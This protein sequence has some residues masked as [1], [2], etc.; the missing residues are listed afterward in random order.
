MVSK[1]KKLLSVTLVLIMVLSMCPTEALEAVIDCTA[2]IA[3]A[4]G[5]II[6][7][8]TVITLSNDFEEHLLGSSFAISAKYSSDTYSHNEDT[9]SYSV[10]GPEEGLVVD[11][12][13]SCIG[14][15]DNG[16]ISIPFKATKT[17]TY[18]VTI[19]SIYGA[20]DS[21]EIYITE[22][23][24]SGY[25][26][27]RLIERKE[28]LQNTEML[29]HYLFDP[30]VDSQDFISSAIIHEKFID[31]PEYFY[32]IVL[33]DILLQQS[34]D[35]NY[36]SYLTDSVQDIGQKCIT[37]TL[38]SI[39]GYTEESLKAAKLSTLSAN[40]REQLRIAYEKTTGISNIWSAVDALVSGAETVEEYFNNLAKYAALQNVNK[41]YIAVLN[42]LNEV[43][44]VELYEHGN[45]DINASSISTACLNLIQIY[46]NKN[47]GVAKCFEESAES[48]IWDL[49]KEA[50]EEVLVLVFGSTV[51][52][53]IKITKEVGLIIA[54]TVFGADEK[55]KATCLIKTTNYIEHYLK[56]AL[57]DI[58]SDYNSNSQSASTYIAAHKLLLTCF[59]YGV[60]THKY[61]EGL[62]YDKTPASIVGTILNSDKK[63]EHQDTL[64]AL[65]VDNNKLTNEYAYITSVIGEF[66]SYYYGNTTQWVITLNTNDEF[67][68]ES[69]ILVYDGEAI[70]LSSRI[71]KR[72]GYKFLGWYYDKEG[73]I[74]FEENTVAT[75]YFTLYA[76]WEQ[77][78]IYITDYDNATNT[79][80][81]GISYMSS[82]VTF[83]LD[84]S[85]K[86]ANTVIE[87][88]AYID[89]YEITRISDYGFAGCDTATSIYVPNTITHIGEYAFSNCTSLLELFIPENVDSIG[90]SIL[91]NCNSDE[92]KIVG[93][94]GSYVEVYANLNNYVFIDINGLL[95]TYTVNSSSG[96]AT[97]TGLAVDYTPT[98]L[99]I[100]NVIDGYKVIAIGN[101]AFKDCTNLVSVVIKD[102]ITSIYS[103]AFKNCNNIVTIELSDSITTISYGAFWNCS[104][105]NSIALGENVSYIDS[106]AFNYCNSLNRVYITDFK[107]WCNINFAGVSSNPLYYAQNL[108]LNNSKLQGEF[109]IPDGVTKIPNYTFKN[110]DIT[111]VTF[112]ASVE[113]IGEQAFYNCKRLQEI[114][115]TN[116][117]TSIGVCAF[118]HCSN[119]SSISLPESLTSIRFETFDECI[120]LKEVS[121]PRSITAIGEYAFSGCSNLKTVKIKD[122]EAWCKID[123][124]WWDYRSSSPLANSADLYLNDE[125]VTEL[126]I[127]SNI[128]KLNKFT[129]AGCSSITSVSIPDSVT[130]IE[131]GVFENCDNL[132]SVSISD[133]VTS[134]GSD[135]FYSC[136]ALEII[137][138][139]SKI[140]RIE[141]RTF[142]GCASLAE[143]SIPNNITSIGLYAFRDCVKLTKIEIPDSVT[144]LSSGAFQNT[145]SLKYIK[146][147]N[148][149]TSSIYGIFTG[150]Y[151]LEEIVIGEGIT[152]LDR[153]DINYP[154][155]FEDWTSLKKVVLGSN[156]E[157]IG[158]YSFE[159][160]SSLEEINI[161]EKVTE[162]PRYTFHNCSSLQQIELPETV[163]KIGEGAFRGCTNLEVINMPEKLQVIDYYAFKDC[164]NLREAILSDE[165][166]TIGYEA[167][168]NCINLKKVTVGGKVTDIYY[169]TFFGCKSLEEIELSEGLLRIGF[170][171]WGNSDSLDEGAFQGCESLEYILLPDSLTAIACNT[172]MDCSNI[173]NIIIPT[174]VSEIETSTFEN[175]TALSKITLHDGITQIHPSAFH[176]TYI[177]NNQESWENGVLYIDSCLIESNDTV[178]SDYIIKDGTV[179]IATGAFK[180]IDLQSIVIPS[181]VQN[182]GSYAFYS[183][184]SWKL[185]DLFYGGSKD[186]WEELIAKSPYTGIGNMVNIHYEAPTNHYTIIESVEATCTTEGKIISNCLC[187]YSKTE[188]IEALGHNNQVIEFMDV[189]CTQ[190]GYTKYKCLTCEEENYSYIWSEGHVKGE[191]LQVVQPTCVENGHTE[192]YCVVCNEICIEYLMPL[193]HAF[194]SGVCLNCNKPQ[195]DCIESSHNYENNC[196]K[197]WVINKLNVDYITIT[198]SSSTETE[199]GWDYIYIY[200]ADDNEIG[201]YTGTELASKEITVNGSVVKIRLTSD[202]SVN[203]YGFALSNV[204]AYR[205]FVSNTVEVVAENTNLDSLAELKVEEADSG[206]IIIS[207]PDNVSQL[208]FYDIYFEKDDERIQPE[209]VVTV[210]IPVP[211]NINGINCKV[212][213]IDDFGNAT[214]MNA[215]YTDG[216]M[217]FT[218]DHFSYYALAE[219][220]A[221]FVYGDANG[222]G[223]IDG[224][225]VI[226]INNY[227]ANYDYDTEASSVEIFEGADANGDGTIDGRDVIRLRNYLA[228]YDYDTDSSTV[229]LG[230]Q[231]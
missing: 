178:S 104:S 175:C 69:D 200:D 39:T 116:N 172:F 221:G 23:T 90:S 11:G 140:T 111:E 218:T 16:F 6:T 29:Y 63:V 189:T 112:S 134:I 220:S 77:E 133:R 21:V 109:L 55:H 193:G 219:D 105:L 191:I 113:S 118:S 141:D 99:Q 211:T 153:P 130:L 147:G 57:D 137:N 179:V 45:I 150:C 125:L 209:G 204:V 132:K 9:I 41:E 198:F 155:I 60:S 129:F 18:I 122:I 127:P 89:G 166:E 24:F 213:H 212:Y 182:I 46:D 230:P 135:C 15:P 215:V 87:I 5:D 70:D 205:K 227:L 145:S 165:I 229:V 195:E 210:S 196:D 86:T 183:T 52:A 79:P 61:Y 156:V 121:I 107:K 32:E 159:G 114:N 151:S 54:N 180:Y 123:F 139:P 190:Y 81:V 167:F 207:L 199:N 131:K 176:N 95:F 160:C 119:I 168:R 228:N 10:S 223:T 149:I 13:M 96:N 88:P 37:Y 174:D 72:N 202:G 164:E 225:D 12:G 163:E 82:P 117:I 143:I 120:N 231:N 42:E 170:D 162:I 1:I 177:Y 28:M 94:G 91:F 73:T 71:P 201:K 36:M 67:G 48:I 136:D 184:D 101:S 51:A 222:D 25:L 76:Q 92:L 59:E 27:S 152:S 44:I 157:N 158:E 26:A 62:L 203:K 103:E 192:Y 169:G 115:F 31:N 75:T 126:I 49:T 214:D 64:N 108:Y 84:E 65:E 30:P 20:T 8:N 35:L 188:Y 50:A 181:S 2:R 19:S 217:V 138:I 100:P 83:S 161:P 78:Y 197:T 74:P 53:T 226:R 106:Y 43:A 80:F 47:I 66:N 98:K 148:G 14:T 102:G 58:A 173:D 22:K 17:G 124:D 194:D 216:Y 93:Y 154:G 171:P 7:S 3:E 68:F 85:P 33:L 128:D 206:N 40:D 97:I 187:G 224:R 185:K 144:T 34:S 186:A 4:S 142:Y 38:D 146:I 110:S 208:M 56:L